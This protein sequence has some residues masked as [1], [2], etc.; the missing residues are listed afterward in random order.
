MNKTYE[1]DEEKQEFIITL[2]IPMYQSG[3]YTYG[4]G[5]WSQ[6]SVCVY[7][8]KKYC[9][10]T[11]NHLNYL[12]YKDSLQTGGPILHFD[13]EQEALKFAEDYKL[14]VEYARTN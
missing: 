1:F 8:D 10:Y 7:I 5:V 9:E 3:E 6:D 11:L 4:D 2:R 13:S 14:M 12:D